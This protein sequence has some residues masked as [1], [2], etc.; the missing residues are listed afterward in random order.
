MTGCPPPPPDPLVHHICFGDSVTQGLSSGVSYPMLLEQLLVDAGFEATGSVANEGQFGDMACGSQGRLIERIDEARYPNAHAVLYW[1]GANDLMWHVY[2]NNFEL[3]HGPTEEDV[4]A[5][6][7][8]VYD[9]INDS[10]DIIE[11]ANLEVAV[12]TYYHL[13]PGHDV[14]GW[15]ETTEEMIVFANQYIDALNQAIISLA[16][17]RGIC[18]APIYELGVLGDGSEEYYLGDG[19]HPNEAGLNLISGVWFDTVLEC[20]Y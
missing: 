7:H 13:V 2:Y 3:D 16:S 14:F 6:N 5:I 10:M 4:Q 8:I 11:E 17:T 15:G 18:L 20:F 19:V 1:L 12:G 9:C